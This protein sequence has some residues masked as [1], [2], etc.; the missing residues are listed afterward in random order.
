MSFYFWFFF[1]STYID[2]WIKLNLS[3][4][5]SKEMETKQQNK[6]IS[7]ISSIV[8]FF[9]SKWFLVCLF[10]CFIFWWYN[11]YFILFVCRNTHT[12]THLATNMK[13]S[14]F[15]QWKKNYPFKLLINRYIEKTC[16]KKVYFEIAEEKKK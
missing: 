9:F 4:Q 5:K 2:K 16:E 8:I 12:H 15:S 10:V 1:S 13:Q 6:K 14:V 3:V 7:I 11:R